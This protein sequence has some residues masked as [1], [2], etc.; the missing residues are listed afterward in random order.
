MEVPLNENPASTEILRV[1]SDTN[2]GQ[3]FSLH[4]TW[5]DPAAW[6]ILLVDIAR[7]AARAYANE[8]AD[9]DD[10]LDRIKKGLDVEWSSPT[11]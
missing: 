3:Y 1:W 6:G 8:G 5:N 2:A 7:H 11:T 4:T 9:Y 10:I